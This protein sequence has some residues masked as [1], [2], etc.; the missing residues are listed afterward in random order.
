MRLVVAASVLEH[1]SMLDGVE[2][3]ECLYTILKDET[4]QIISHWE[5]MHEI[6]EMPTLSEAVHDW[7]SAMLNRRV[8]CEQGTKHLFTPPLGPLP[9]ESQQHFYLLTMAHQADK[10]VLYCSV[11]SPECY[12]FTEIDHPDFSCVEWRDTH[13][14]SNLLMAPVYTSQG[15]SDG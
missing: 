10:V 14:A 9:K 4:I 6:N 3:L 2:C 7:K 13:T 8:R 5:W 12:K 15:N 1:A 11:R